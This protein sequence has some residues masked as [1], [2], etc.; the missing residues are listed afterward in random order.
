M[1]NTDQPKQ[2]GEG[3]GCL[4]WSP[5]LPLHYVRRKE[6]HS[7]YFC[8]SVGKIATLFSYP[9]TRGIKYLLSV[10]KMALGRLFQIVP[11]FQG[12]FCIHKLWDFLLKQLLTLEQLLLRLISLKQVFPPWFRFHYIKAINLIRPQSGSSSDWDKK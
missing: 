10:S 6:C 11:E 9:A 8:V 5:A 7:Q 12:S 2:F 4:Q 1:Q 3:K